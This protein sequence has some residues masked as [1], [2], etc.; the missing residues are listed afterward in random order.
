[1]DIVEL[2]KTFGVIAAGLL[3]AAG[4]WKIYMGLH[5]H[6]LERFMSETVKE[7]KSSLKDLL[8]RL[9]AQDA[10]LKD[11]QSEVHPNHGSSLRDSVE[12]M[13]EQMTIYEII[14]QAHMAESGVGTFQ[15]DKKGRFVRVNVELCKMF[16]QTEESLLRSGF[17]S[18]LSK[19][20]SEQVLRSWDDAV[21]RH[22]DWR[23]NDIEILPD[24][25][26]LKDMLAQGT[27]PMRVQVKTVAAH[28]HKGEFIGYIGFVRRW[29][30]R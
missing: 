2:F 17:S 13:R 29:T 16:D 8:E 1:M 5:T 10:I 25:R 26:A 11:V 20:K 19:F 3:A 4:L 24:D 28:D 14:T 30:Q 27:K 18:V 21:S 12:H 15:T 22:A 23:R 6:L 7:T 9:D